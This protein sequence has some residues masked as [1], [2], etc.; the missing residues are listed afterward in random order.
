MQT[1]VPILPIVLAAG[2]SARMGYPKALLPLGEELFITRILRILCAAD[3]PRPTVVLGKAAPIIRPCMER[4]SADI[5]VNSSPQRGQLSSIQLALEGVG[6]DYE[7]CMIWPVDQPAVSE[8][9]VR[10]LVQLFLTSQGPIVLPMCG[11]KRGHPA[12]FHR[13]LFH[14]FMD[15]P[16]SEGPKGIL[17]RHQSEIQIFATDESAAVEDIDT[18]QDYLK[19]TGYSLETAMEEFARRYPLNQNWSYGNKA[20]SL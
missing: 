8:G 14:E 3:L 16:L 18:P 5:R 15:A 11:A 1:T 2:D 6:P 12:I 17:V 10:G 19:L 4:W 13:E 9:L 20:G 7:G